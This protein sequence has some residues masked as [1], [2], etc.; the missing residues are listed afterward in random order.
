MIKGGL[1]CGCGRNGCF[2]QYASATALIRQTKELMLTDKSSIMWDFC[3]GDI[4]NVS[5]ITAFACAKKGDK[6]ANLVIEN[7]VSYLSE[8]IWDNRFRYVEELK[9]MGASIKV[10]GKTAIIE[11][12][13]PLSPAPVRAVDLR[14]GAAMV[15]AALT[16]NGRT[17]IEDIHHI[18]RG[19]D[20]IVQK[21]RSVGADIKKII[22]P[23][24]SFYEKAN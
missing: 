6:T 13:N 14:A 17:E 8:G 24:S 23:D 2:E 22:V 4:E 12:G 18:E 21:L 11:G 15:I 1:K 7:Y 10:D 20:D 3:D 9:R 5:G 16:V 19:Y